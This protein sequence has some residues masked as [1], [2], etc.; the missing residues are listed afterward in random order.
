[1]HL[2]KRMFW[3]VLSH[4][5]V[6]SSDLDENNIKG[7]FTLLYPTIT[8]NMIEKNIALKECFQTLDCMLIVIKCKF[9]IVYVHFK[10]N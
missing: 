6:P 5:C 8:E 2:E 1:M 4:V 7:A 9:V 10:C 3:K